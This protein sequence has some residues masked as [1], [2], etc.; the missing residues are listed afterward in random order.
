MPPKTSGKA[1][2]K[3]GKAQK[4]ISKT[5]KKKT[6]P[7][8]L[9]ALEFVSFVFQPSS[10]R[11]TTTHLNNAEVAV[12]VLVSLLC[13]FFSALLIVGLYKDRP[14]YLKAYM[15]YAII[16]ITFSTIGFF[17]LLFTRPSEMGLR[18]FFNMVIS[19]TLLV[20]SLLA[21]RAYHAQGRSYNNNNQRGII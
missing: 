16:V 1:A 4:N 13:L 18:G 17:M 20:L 14:S 3:S 10:M 21:V 6:A 9:E 8:I 7:A 19:I 15:I 11:P 2:K 12:G 5:D